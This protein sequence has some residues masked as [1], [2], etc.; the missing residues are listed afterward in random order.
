[1]TDFFILMMLQKN[2]LFKLSWLIRKLSSVQ[3]KRKSKVHWADIVNV[4][5][6]NG[7]FDD[8]KYVAM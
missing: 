8:E 2:K 3:L 6:K 1:M 5:P 4:N 7:V